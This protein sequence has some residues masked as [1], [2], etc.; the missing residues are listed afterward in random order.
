M[1]DYEKKMTEVRHLY[2]QFLS[3]ILRDAQDLQLSD[4]YVRTDSIYYREPGPNGF[5]GSAGVYFMLTI[6]EPTDLIYDAE[7]WSD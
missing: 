4:V 3:R 2:M 6:D 7:Q 5:N 1:Q